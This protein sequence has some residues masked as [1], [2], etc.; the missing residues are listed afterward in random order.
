[1]TYD[2]EMTQSPVPQKFRAKVDC[3]R[4]AWVEKSL[5]GTEICLGPLKPGKEVKAERTDEN[6]KGMG[7]KRAVTETRHSCVLELLQHKLGDCACYLA[8]QWK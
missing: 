1:M 2:K 4:L 6:I 3:P 8:D 5:E 7:T